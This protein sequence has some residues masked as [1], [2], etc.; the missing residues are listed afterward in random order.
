MWKSQG[1]AKVDPAKR[2]VNESSEKMLR[3]R[4]TKPQHW[5]TYLA[6]VATFSALYSPTFL[7]YCSLE[8]SWAS[9]LIVPVTNGAFAPMAFA[10]VWPL[11]GAEKC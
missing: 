2:E 4:T 8:L 10:S 3:L 6:G 7:L 11:V 5:L 9:L 1:D